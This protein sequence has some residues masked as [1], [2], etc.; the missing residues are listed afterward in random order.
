MHCWLIHFELPRTPAWMK[1]IWH[2]AFFHEARHSSAVLR[3]ARQHFTLCFG[4]ILNSK[5]TSKNTNAKNMAWNALERG[6]SERGNRKAE[7]SASPARGV[8]R[9]GRA[10]IRLL[11]A[12][13][14]DRRAAGALALSVQTPCSS[15][16]VCRTSPWQWGPA[17]NREG[18]GAMLSGTVLTPEFPWVE[19]KYLLE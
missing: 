7:P 2:V 9:R 10:G 6:R 11:C 8:N 15:R 4:V 14:S 18:T 17:V 13:L 3:D 1:C 19:N 12:S 16:W 5:N